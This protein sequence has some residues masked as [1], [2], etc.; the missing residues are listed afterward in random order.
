MITYTQH[1]PKPPNTISL[2]WMEFSL[3]EIKIIVNNF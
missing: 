3:I 2:K 1:Y